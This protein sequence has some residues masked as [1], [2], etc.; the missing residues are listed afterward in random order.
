MNQARS[1]RSVLLGD[2]KA[3]FVFK[4]Y[5]VMYSYLLCSNYADGPNPQGSFRYGSINVTEI[6]VLRNKPPETIDGKRRATLSGISF[7]NPAIPI[8]LADQFKLK[9]VYKLDFYRAA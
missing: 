9:G 1:I 5:L 2:L 3:S 7:V 6:Y 4:L 8:R